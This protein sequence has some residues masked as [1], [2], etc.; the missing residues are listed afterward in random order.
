MGDTYVFMNNTTYEQ[1]EIPA[2]VLGD[3]INFNRK[4][5]MDCVDDI[6]GKLFGSPKLD[7]RK[8]PRFVY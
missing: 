8:D 3:N 2:S 6:R 7:L 4:V 1:I 5:L